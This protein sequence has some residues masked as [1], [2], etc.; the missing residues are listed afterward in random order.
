VAFN[1]ETGTPMAAKEIRFQEG[2]NLTHLK[3]VQDELEV[4]QMLHHP[5]IVEFYGMEVHRDRVFIF[6]EYCGGGD[7]G[8]VLANGKIEEEVAQLYTLQIIEGLE[9]L[10][11]Q[12]VVHRDIKPDSE[13]CT[14]FQP[15]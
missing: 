14:T 11:S 1:L 15:L 4:M 10:H 2:A 8:A 6:E 12:G 7:L 13:F 5:N 9:Y 3:Q